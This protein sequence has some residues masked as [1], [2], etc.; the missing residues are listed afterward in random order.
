MARIGLEAFAV[1][2]GFEEV[3]FAGICASLGID[4]GPHGDLCIDA[5]V[6]AMGFDGLRDQQNSDAEQAE[7]AE[8]REYGVGVCSHHLTSRELLLVVVDH[9]SLVCLVSA[10]GQPCGL[11]GLEQ[12]NCQPKPRPEAL[13]GSPAIRNS[14]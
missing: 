7:T 1:F 5:A 9:V 6:V 13:E 8:S 14:M 11:I 3:H 10:Y 12:C 2:D 4:A